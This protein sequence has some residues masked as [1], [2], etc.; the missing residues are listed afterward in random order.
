ME[1]RGASPILA[2]NNNSANAVLIGKSNIQF[3]LRNSRINM[4]NTLNAI[5]TCFLCASLL[6]SNIFGHSDLFVSKAQA[7]SIGASGLPLPRFVSLK[8]TRVNMRVGPSIEYKV[9]W[10]FTRRGLPLEI[11]QEFDNWRKVRDSE[12]DEGWI[13]KSLLS[14]E[15]T[16][17]VSPWEK[18]N[19]DI[20]IN[21]WIQPDTSTQLIAK[22][23]PGVLAQ[24]ETCDK[25]W[26]KIIIDDKNI[27]G[28]AKQSV[29]WGVYPDE[30]IK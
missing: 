26:C 29:L 18:T 10:L 13:N 25:D 14:G 16:V 4:K 19:S 8:S 28:F 6:A 23:E 17:L 1:L 7:Q 30:T 9:E 27:T 5:A 22:L 24:V 15:R 21:L 3:I 12:G 11:L 2:Q 20:L